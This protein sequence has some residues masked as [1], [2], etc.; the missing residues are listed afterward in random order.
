MK[1]TYLKTAAAV[2]SFLLLNPGCNKDPDRN[3]KG[4]EPAKKEMSDLERFNSNETLTRCSLYVIN[5]TSPQF[6]EVID[7]GNIAYYGL[8]LS[9]RPDKDLAKGLIAANRDGL[10]EYQRKY[11]VTSEDSALVIEGLMASGVEEDIILKALEA[12]KERF[13]DTDGGCFRTVNRG[14]AEYWKG[15]SVETTAHIAYLMH[16]ADRK[17]FE[18]EIKVSAEYVRNNQDIDGKWSGKWFPS[19]TITSYYAVRFLALFDESF[20]QN[21]EKNLSYLAQKQSDNGSWSNS[22]IET[23]AAVLLIKS[24]GKEA[25]SLSKAG[26]WLKNSS[27]KAEPILYYWFEKENNKLF[28]DCWDKGLLVEAWKKLAL[29]SLK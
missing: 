18:N 5:E 19:I 27:F 3:V 22:I 6:K 2:I 17:K 25:A 8:L 23:S 14:R 1:I 26:E 15:C 11:G 10:W 28:F 29:D 20:S 12:L 4:V 16:K 7:E 9:A 24:S 13:F 21:I